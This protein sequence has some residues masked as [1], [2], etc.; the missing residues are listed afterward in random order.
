MSKFG[1]IFACF[2]EVFQCLKSGSKVG[3]K[4]PEL[5]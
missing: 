1:P 2:L 4:V 5:W 3:S